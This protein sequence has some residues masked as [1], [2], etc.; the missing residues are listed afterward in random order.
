MQ[1]SV[2]GLYFE[3]EHLVCWFEVLIKSVLAQLETVKFC[4]NVNQFTLV[5][6]LF[7]FELDL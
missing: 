6:N 3:V 1:K 7:N 2:L 4:S 5:L